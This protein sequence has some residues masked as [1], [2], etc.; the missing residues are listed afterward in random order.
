MI[1]SG[2]PLPSL[3]LRDGMGMLSLVSLVSKF[4]LLQY[5][6]EERG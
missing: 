3:G 1:D 5:P 4:Q 2:E 6:Y